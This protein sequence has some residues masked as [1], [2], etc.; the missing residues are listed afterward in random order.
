ML[1]LVGEAVLLSA[2]LLVIQLTGH[3][4]W[5]VYGACVLRSW[6]WCSRRT[7]EGPPGAYAVLLVT[8]PGG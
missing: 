1:E 7:L 3:A 5:P 6:G 4:G 8:C 2:V